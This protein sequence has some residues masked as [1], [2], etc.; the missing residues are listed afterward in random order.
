MVS[1]DK[2]TL[3]R[4]SR[5]YTFNLTDL[6]WDEIYPESDYKPPGTSSAKLALYSNT[7]F[8]FYGKKAEGINADVFSFSLDTHTWKIEY[9]EGENFQG[10]VYSAFTSFEYNNTVYAAIFGGLT[11]SGSSNDLFL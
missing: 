6:N 9:L 3:Q 1:T 4:T 10:R 2:M 11:H 8:V 7:L 5:L